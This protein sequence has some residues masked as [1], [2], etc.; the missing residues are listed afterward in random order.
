MEFEILAKSLIEQYG[1]IS[2]FLIVMLE[3]AN[4][5][6]PS[7][8]VLPFIGIMVSKG[9]IDFGLALTISIIGGIVGSTINYLLGLYFGKP[10]LKYMMKKYPKTRYS[11]KSSMWW[12]NKYGKISVMLA[13]VI[14]VART[15][16]SIPAGIN[17]MNINIFV[18][19]STIGISLWN[20]ILIFLGYILGD[21][22]SNIA[23][24]IKNYSLIVGIV[25]VSVIVI[26]YSKKRKKI[27]TSCRK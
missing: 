6:L 10:I 1:L 27:G 9:N 26:I 20:T 18:L 15:I 22:L 5:P 21:N 12:M 19:Y 13:R 23:Y 4:F 8:V 25:L 24:L 2:I 17:K 16:I 3:Y 11:I 14:P 7:E